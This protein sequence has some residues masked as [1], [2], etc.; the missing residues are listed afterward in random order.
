MD[1]TV[2]GKPSTI[3]TCVTEV[4]MLGIKQ[5]RIADADWEAFV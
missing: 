4:F 5:H 2:Y 3:S 1:S